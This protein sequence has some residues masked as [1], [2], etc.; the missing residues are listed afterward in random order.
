MTTETSSQRNKRIAK[1]T[2]LLYF[3]MLI[4]MG[5][6]LYTVRI[7]LNTLGVEDYGLYSVVGGIVALLAFL[8]GTMASATQRFFSHALGQQDQ[9][10]LNRI[11]GVNTLVYIGISLL[12]LF[13]LKTGGAW[14]VE[15]HLSVPDGRSEAVNQV[16][17]IAGFTFAVTIF[18]SPFM[19]MIIAHEDMVIYAY[20]AIFDALLKLGIV[21]LLVQLPGD[22]IVV[23]SWLLLAVAI[24]DT[25]LY[26]IIC[27]RKYS[28]CSLRNIRWDGMLAKEL[29]G[30]TGWTLFGALT[31]VARGAAVTILLNQ[32]FSPVVIAARAIALNIST[33]SN[34]LS[35]QFNTSLYPPIIKAYSAGRREEMYS[36]VVNGSKA[37]FFLM[38]ILVLPLFIEMEALLTIWLKEPPEYAVIF[39]KLT[40]VEALILS[41]SK[42]LATAARAPGRMALYESILGTLQF[43]ILFVSWVL[44]KAGHGPESVFY[45]AIAVNLIMFCVRLLLV[46]H[47]TGLPVLRYLKETLVP[48]LGVVAVSITIPAAVAYY[49]PSG[50]IYLV[51]SLGTSVLINALTICFLGLPA[52]M[53]KTVFAFASR[54]LH[55]V[56]NWL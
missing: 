51:L 10:R 22:K 25:L 38:W 26:L 28:E 12:A 1:N 44:L 20:M 34:M 36:L 15:N 4:T 32:Y 2:L 27:F 33:K 8:P 41:I 54:K 47:L 52:S 39:A 31:T 7:V 45:V 5:V 23:Y 19:A 40:L 21:F 53:R 9:K 35:G 17:Y 50:A 46:G 24:V 16:F 49:M 29:A 13:I 37:T 55:S 43:G 30:F 3:R 14:F 56:K 42:P 18:K 6:S 11:F 48:V